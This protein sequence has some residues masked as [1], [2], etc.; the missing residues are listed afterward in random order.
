MLGN[1]VYS[2]KKKKNE[3]ESK[4]KIQ[5]NINNKIKKEYPKI[6]NQKITEIIKNSK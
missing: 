3:L 1:K 4:I 5:T 6:F 2:L